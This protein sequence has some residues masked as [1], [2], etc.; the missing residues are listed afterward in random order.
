MQESYQILSAGLGEDHART[1][2]ARLRIGELYTR[3]NE[4]DPSPERARLA[5][6]W[7]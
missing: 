5:E 2:D 1:Q 4:A 3:W 7:Q 6:E